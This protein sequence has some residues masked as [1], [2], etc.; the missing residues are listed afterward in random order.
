[1]TVLSQLD[2][3][4]NRV[5]K[6]LI[7]SIVGFENKLLI[8]DTETVKSIDWKLDPG[9]VYE[10]HTMNGDFVRISTLW[11][12]VTFLTI[13]CDSQVRGILIYKMN[14]D[15]RDLFSHFTH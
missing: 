12:A 6:I 14:F 10:V 7:D 3:T 8:L 5:S 11:S 4:D 9:V 13:L 15:V 1:M 2:V